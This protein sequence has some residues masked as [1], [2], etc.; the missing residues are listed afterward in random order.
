MPFTFICSIQIQIIEMFSFLWSGGGAHKI[1]GQLWGP[2]RLR[3]LRRP[4][5]NNGNDYHHEGRFEKVGVNYD[6]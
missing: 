5:P 4:I 1:D 6:I 3:M 2:T